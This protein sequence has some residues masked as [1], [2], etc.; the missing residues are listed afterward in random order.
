MRFHFF[1][2]AVNKWWSFLLFLYVILV[3]TQFMKLHD[4][5]RFPESHVSREDRPPAT[6]V[7]CND[8][9]DVMRVSEIVLQPDPPEKGANLT[10]AV[11]G[12]LEH[13]VLPGAYLDARIKKSGIRF[14][15]VRVSVC[16][17]LHAGC[18]VAK[19]STSMSMTFDIPKLMPG[20]QYEIEAALYTKRTSGNPS[21]LSMMKR[22]MGYNFSTKQ[23]DDLRVFCLQGTMQL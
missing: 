3:A 16:E 10:V 20:G 5:R 8:E 11:D 7:L 23:N 9:S 21:F 6:V 19:G 18:P 14:P 1:V 13:D 12:F 17:Y 22:C 4:K 2:Y 15:Q